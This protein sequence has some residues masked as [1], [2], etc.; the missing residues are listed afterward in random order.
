MRPRAMPI[1]VARPGSF[2]RDI[3][4]VGGEVR[5]TF[6][7]LQPFIWIAVIWLV[8]A[9]VFFRNFLFSGFDKIIGDIGDARFDIFLR[10]NF[11]QFLRGEA[12]FLSPPMFFP[13][14]GTLGYSDA[15]LLD[16]LIYVPLR[17]V[18][19]DPFL[20]FELLCVGLSLVGFV[21]TNI[22]LMRFAGVRQPL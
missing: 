17:V 16:G 15:Y 22:L 7:S 2:G 8:A 4:I 6:A 1:N 12:E 10:E 13:V 19:L 18:G 11:L 20:S 9:A 3:R 5:L 21:S 14:K